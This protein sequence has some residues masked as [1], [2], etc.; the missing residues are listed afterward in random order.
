MMNPSYPEDLYD[1]D[2][3]YVEKKMSALRKE[4]YSH[5]LIGFGLGVMS[6]VGLA[7]AVAWYIGP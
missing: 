2:D 3:Y 1:D 6:T 4:M 5:I 7:S